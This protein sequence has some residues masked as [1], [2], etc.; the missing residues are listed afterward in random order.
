M[1]PPPAGP[2]HQRSRGGATLRFALARGETRLADLH[3][4]PPIRVLFPRPERG[5]P[6][7]AA[8]VNTAG[9][10][11][12]GDAVEIAVAV[13]PGA[14]ATVSTP[15][16]EKVYRSLGPETRVAARLEVAAGAALEWIPQETIL[17][18]GAR[19]A[20]RFE[21]HLAPDAMLLMAEMIVF[22]RHARGEVLQAGTLLDTW[23]VHRGGA[24]LWA[25]GVA[26]QGEIRARLEDPFG[27][28]GAEAAATLLL[29]AQGPLTDARDALRDA[30]A[31]ASL[32][33]PG[34]LVARWL[35]RAA[36]LREGL[37]LAIRLLRREALGV[38]PVLPRLWTC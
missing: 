27:F 21:A 7:L 3:Q 18:N 14:R 33:R 13:G 9:G 2:A 22:G 1:R 4:V 38:P 11:A 6:P 29:A 8:L 23:R 25:D 15:A 12:G 37:G 35:G 16:A 19:L 36:E 5:E 28:A 32:V 17:F 26:L 24:L 31:A 10:L 20:R 30:G 34:L